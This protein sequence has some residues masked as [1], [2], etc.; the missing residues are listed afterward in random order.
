MQWRLAKKTIDKYSMTKTKKE[1]KITT[2]MTRG[3]EFYVKATKTRQ[4][5]P[6][7]PSS[8]RQRDSLLLSD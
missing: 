7:A 1:L 5:Q 4:L 8:H 3:R 2:M 6:D